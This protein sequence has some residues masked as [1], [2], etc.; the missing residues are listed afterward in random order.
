MRGKGEEVLDDAG[1]YKRSVPET[2]VGSVR[3]LYASTVASR[4]TMSHAPGGA[5]V[6][7]ACTRGCMDSHH[8]IT[9]GLARYAAMPK[10]SLSVRAVYCIRHHPA[11]PTQHRGF[12]PNL[13]LTTD[14][15]LHTNPRL[16]TDPQ[17]HT[18]PRLN[19]DPQLHT[20]PWLNTDP[21]A[22]HG[23]TDAATHS[24]HLYRPKA[25]RWHAHQHGVKVAVPH[26]P[27]TPHQIRPPTPADSRPHAP[28]STGSPS[29]HSHQHGIKITVPHQPT[30][31]LQICPSTPAD[32]R[33]HAPSSTG[34]SSTARSPARH[35]TRVRPGRTSPAGTATQTRRPRCAEAAT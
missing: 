5:W 34:S 22:P 1:G 17:L 8:L 16:N 21:T 2:M 4:G 9:S 6:H 24:A 20:N 14:P 3:R 29:Q 30:I 26:Q 11:Q 33:H 27:T 25:L 18:N 19:T 13:R 12:A 28:S 15:Q 35:Q 10:T 32:S 23:T 31:P 7:T